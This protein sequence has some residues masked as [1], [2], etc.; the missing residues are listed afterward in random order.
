MGQHDA[1]LKRLGRAVG[2]AQD[3]ALH[4]ASSGSGGVSF[5]QGRERLLVSMARARQSGSAAAST[6]SRRGTWVGGGVAFAAALA[7]AVAFLLLRPASMTFQ[8]ADGER[9][10]VGGWLAAPPGGELPLSFS[11]GTSVRLDREARARVA[12]I[13]EKGA[14][15]VLES[16]RARASVIHREDTRWDVDVGPYQVRVTG[17]RFDVSWDPTVEVFLLVLEEGSVRVTGPL[18]G[19]G[20]A[21]V[22]GQT[23]RA[24]VKEQ[25]LE[26]S[27]GGKPI[28]AAPA[29]DPSQPA[30]ALDPA[31]APPPAPAPSGDTPPATAAAEPEPIDLDDPAALLPSGR[32]NPPS[33]SGPRVP[34]WR[35]LAAAG[36]YKEALAAVEKLGFDEVCAT[37]SPGDL[38][39]LSDAARLAGSGARATQAL[40]ALRERFPGDRR[41]SMAAFVQGKIAFDQRG[42]YADAARWFETYLREQPAG[43]VARE[44]A[45]RLMEARQRAGDLQGARSAAESYLKAY[46][47]GPHAEMARKLLGD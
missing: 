1:A 9:G 47:M 24:A 6:R 21:V 18:L 12:R 11:D 38:M 3:E 14:Q 32:A 35:Q 19:D 27:A 29:A 46:P 43:P 10:T 26:I 28:A 4:G 36:K 20:L 42:A 7:A 22:A 37:G 34:V 16:G 8:V 41:A 23:V 45:G 33:A 13:D 25:R 31:T 30:P 5:E 44:A 17:T 2:D 15:L 40:K 39:T